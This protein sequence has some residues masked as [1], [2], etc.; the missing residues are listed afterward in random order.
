MTGRDKLLTVW[1]LPSHTDIRLLEPVPFPVAS[2]LAR[3][4]AARRIFIADARLEKRPAEVHGQNG[5]EFVRTGQAGARLL[6]R[7]PSNDRFAHQHPHQGGE[8]GRSRHLPY[9]LSYLAFNGRTR[10]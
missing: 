5:Q 2:D 4:F 10:A 8:Q 6:I 1:A 3:P 7:I 9:H